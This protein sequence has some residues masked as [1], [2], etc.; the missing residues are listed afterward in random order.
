MKVITLP[1]WKVQKNCGDSISRVRVDV[2]KLVRR[3]LKSQ[4][5][6]QDFSSL[7]R[8]LVSQRL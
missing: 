1:L 2:D 6:N 3:R 5:Q 8:G 4:T 7:C